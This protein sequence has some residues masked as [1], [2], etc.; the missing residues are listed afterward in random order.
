M[1][2]KVVA[3]GGRVCDGLLCVITF[4]MQMSMVVVSEDD[5]SWWLFLLAD[6]VMVFYVSSPF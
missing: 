6:C 2:T 1:M 5:S 4:L 3:L